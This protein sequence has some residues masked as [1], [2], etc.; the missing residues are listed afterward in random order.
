MLRLQI[1]EANIS[2]SGAKKVTDAVLG[3]QHFVSGACRH[4]E[5]RWRIS[6]RVWLTSALSENLCV[7]EISK[8]LIDSCLDRLQQSGVAKRLKLQ[9]KCESNS[10]ATVYGKFAAEWN[11]NLSEFRIVPYF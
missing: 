1:Q 2:N 4:Q 11:H 5:R 9:F 10:A 3:Y 6:W 8:K 7:G